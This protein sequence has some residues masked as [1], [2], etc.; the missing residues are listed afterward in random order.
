MKTNGQNKQIDRNVLR[1]FNG[2]E[3]ANNNESWGEG[4]GERPQ[5]S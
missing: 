1:T 2:E 3:M 4:F 5:M